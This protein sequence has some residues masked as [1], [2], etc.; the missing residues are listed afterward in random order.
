MII[1]TD[2]KKIGGCS[3]KIWRMKSENTQINLALERMMR[4]IKS[5]CKNVDQYDRT[6]PVDPGGE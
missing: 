2:T 3:L 4:C 1:Y 5:F 6:L